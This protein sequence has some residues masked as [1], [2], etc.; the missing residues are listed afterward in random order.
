MV[1]KIR[2]NVDIFRENVNIYGGNWW[3]R[4]VHMIC[5]E[6]KKKRNNLYNIRL[7]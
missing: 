5:I 3:K 2:L 7:C 1:Y 4:H 6:K